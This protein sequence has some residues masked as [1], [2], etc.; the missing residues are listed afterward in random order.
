MAHKV[1]PDPNSGSPRDAPGTVSIFNGAVHLAHGALEKASEATKNTRSVIKRSSTK[2]FSAMETGLK[3]SAT[4][5]LT[6]L[7][8]AGEGMIHSLTAAGEFLS[9]G[10]LKKLVP[11]FLED[12]ADGNVNSIIQILELDSVT[13]DF[14]IVQQKDE[15]GRTAFHKA[16]LEGQSAVMKVLI[17]YIDHD[18]ELAYLVNEKD[19]YG[20]TPFFL[21]CM[22]LHKGDPTQ[23]QY[24]ISHGATLNLVK[25]HSL[26]TPLHWAAYHGS[27]ALAE[28]ILASPEGRALV[29]KKNSNGLYPIDMLG[30]QYMKKIYEE[31]DQDIGDSILAEF[32]RGNTA[33]EFKEFIALL[34]LY[35]IHDYPIADYQN[36]RLYWACVTDNVDAARMAIQNQ[37]N[38]S[39]INRT[40]R[41]QNSFHAASRHGSE[42]CLTMLLELVASKKELQTVLNC[43]DCD[44]NTPL[45]ESVRMTNFGQEYRA[46]NINIVKVLLGAGAD[47]TQRNKAN[48][49]ARSYAKDLDFKI[50]LDDTPSARKVASVCPLISYDWVFVFA[51][52]FISFHEGLKPQYYKV[53]EWFRAKNLTVDVFVSTINHDE[54]FVAVTASE[55]VLKSGAEKFR[56]EVQLLSGREYRRYKLAEDF[57]YAPFKTQE[58]L[59]II[60]LIIQD[61][62]D[63]KAYLAGGV[64]KRLFSV[65]DE[66]EL[67]PI[68]ER[69]I[70]HVQPFAAWKDYVTDKES[71]TMEDINH[72]RSYYGE[73]VAFYYA[74]LCH[75]TATLTY[76]VPFSIAVAFYQ[77][78]TESNSSAFLAF[79]AIILVLWSAFSGE[80]WKNKQEELAFR[81]DKLDFELEEETR[82][83]FHGDETINKKTGF[84]EKYYSESARLK[85]ELVSL[86]TIVLF[87]L[88][89]F[90]AYM[91]INLWKQIISETETGNAKTAWLFAASVT[92]SIIVVVL[93]AA[94]KRVALALTDWE[95][96]QTESEWE[97]HY[98]F[99]KFSFML[100]NNTMGGFYTA[101]FQ[102]DIQQLYTMMLTLV[103]VK[104]T[105]NVMKYVAVPLIKTWPKRKKLQE[106]SAAVDVEVETQW[107]YHVP[108]RPELSKPDIL[109]ARLEVGENDSMVPWKGTVNYFS[110]YMIQYAF[111]VFFSLAF[112]L[113]GFVAWAFNLLTIRGEMLVNTSVV[114]RAHT[115]GA[116]NIGSWQTIQETMGLA[117]IVVNVSILLFTMRGDLGTLYVGLFPTYDKVLWSLIVL[118][119]ILLLLQILVQ[120]IIPNQPEWVIEAVAHSNFQRDVS[121]SKQVEEH[122]KAKGRAAEITLLRKQLDEA[123]VTS[124]YLKKQ[125]GLP[126]DFVCGDATETTAGYSADTPPTI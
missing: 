27:V 62:L 40:F 24:L 18:P 72:I 94:W 79:Y 12:A 93:D 11:V 39:S 65:H 99:K 17:E 75:Y 77:Y 55:D 36:K 92:Y 43:R 31:S 124:A 15:E 84:V 44:G 4:I 103:L 28:M 51:K 42:R 96:H 8:N 82:P 123:M 20:S 105:S 126:P 50:M 115:T 54:V 9:P 85:K 113:L 22:K 86:P 16:A 91:V 102:R 112:P 117:S 1:A 49:S 37:A 109:K 83:N 10:D 107:A 98:I 68:R 71:N 111:V 3:R 106:L 67:E 13:D 5:T 21:L 69:W 101:S 35:P 89:I 60:T 125:L 30:E 58:R 33:A 63:V 53:A 56:Y 25:R 23:A 118:E 45:V 64:I 19:V 100:I 74:W 41:F 95:N 97:N 14:S 46:R 88:A 80:T 66:S 34:L 61:A 47:D 70:K 114:Q 81:W 120:K 119:H 104:H 52:G 59:E 121:A 32:L 26:M 73:K 87:A 57:L 7:K 48:F 116:R 110:D 122:D 2:T 108:G 29:L 6:G 78:L 76:I 38:S 90:S